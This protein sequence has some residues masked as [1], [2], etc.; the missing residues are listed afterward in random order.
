MY[1]QNMVQK[2]IAKPIIKN[3]LELLKLLVKI[4]NILIFNS[5]IFNF[6]HSKHHDE[7]VWALELAKPRFQ[8]DY[9]LNNLTQ[10]GYPG[11]AFVP[12]SIK[13]NGHD[14]IYTSELLWGPNEINM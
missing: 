13:E 8:S 9:Y 14:K 12:S 4:H 11:G 1:S 5:K 3:A 6:F 10:I 7:K 2:Y